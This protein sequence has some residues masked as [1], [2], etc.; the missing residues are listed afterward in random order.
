MGR[1]PASFTCQ[2]YVELNGVRYRC[3]LLITVL[4]TSRYL[5]KAYVYITMLNELVILYIILAESLSLRPD[6]IVQRSIET[7]YYSRT[8][9]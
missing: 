9:Q 4:I 7:T 6:T 3:G 5:A 1:W 8:N 2:R